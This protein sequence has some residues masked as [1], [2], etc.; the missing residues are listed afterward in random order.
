MALKFKN[1]TEKLI[2]DIIDTIIENDINEVDYIGNLKPI[3]SLCPDKRYRIEIKGNNGNE[4]ELRM[5]REFYDT[6]AKW[7]KQINPEESEKL[8]LVMTKEEAENQE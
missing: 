4:I 5:T 3:F 2:F 7:F 6:I 8:F 1:P